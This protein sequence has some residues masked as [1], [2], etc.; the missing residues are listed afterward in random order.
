MATTT[1]VQRAEDARINGVL[2]GTAWAGGRITYS[3]PDSGADYG[4]G[5][6]SDADGDGRSAQV[7]GFSRLG[8]AQIGV[9]QRAL[10]IVSKAAAGFSVEG[11]TN[12][13]VVNAGAGSGAGD[14]RIAN[15]NDISTSYAYLPGT[16]MGGDVW[17]GGSGRAPRAGNYDNLII[18]H[19]IGH[20]LGLK[21]SHESWGH[22]FDKL[23]LGLDTLEYTVMTYRPFQGASPTGYRFETWGAPQTYMMLD[24]AALQEMYGADYTTNAGDTVYE[25]TP[26][27]GRTWVNGTVAID[28]GGDRI[29]ATVWD[30]GGHDTYDLSAYETGVTVDLRPGQHSV[31]SKGQLADLGGGPNGGHARGN[32]FNALLHDDD[33]RSLIETAI[34]GSGGDRLIG[35]QGA[36][37]LRG[38]AG[39]DRLEAA[40]GN[41]LLDGGIGNDRLS[42]GYG[43]DKL[44]GGA[45]ADTLFG[46]TGSDTLIG[47]SGADTF[48]FRN[49]AESPCGRADHVTARSGGVAFDAPGQASGDRIDLSAIDADLV[50]AG[51]QAFVFGGKGR[52][53]LWFAEGGTVTIVYANV[54]DDAAPEFELCIHD[55]SVRSWAYTVHDF[56]L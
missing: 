14:I 16:G 54:D 49:V 42:G 31:F 32:I 2:S 21:H 34:G 53:H 10:D 28:P 40:A 25:W 3:L 48:L 56:I 37:T 44:C 13:S 12:L 23:A 8:S 47:D 41:D 20:A 35:N 1:S 39:G 26:G 18:L 17:I 5:Y 7:D 43:A 19:E 24:I 55:G 46:G 6:R 33:P 52:G 29:F 27:S 30:G 51:N 38:G 50:V 36:N 22:G 15:S 11:F 9:A 45:G 4:V